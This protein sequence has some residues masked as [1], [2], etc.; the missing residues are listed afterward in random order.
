V[1]L[2][3]S[4]DN[5]G[6]GSTDRRRRNRQGQAHSRRADRH[7]SHTVP[8]SNRD[9]TPR[10]RRRSVR[11][12]PDQTPSPAPY[13]AAR[14]APQPPSRRRQERQPSPELPMS[15]SCP[16]SIVSSETT[17]YARGCCPGEPARQR[18]NTLNFSHKKILTSGT[19]SPLLRY[20]CVGEARAQP[21]RRSS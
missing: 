6:G 9:A 3:T 21:R 16:S 4:D 12:P 14:Q 1:M 18:E 8:R 13:D 15:S 17:P 11:R 20:A 5:N 10:S 19:K 2:V 7:N